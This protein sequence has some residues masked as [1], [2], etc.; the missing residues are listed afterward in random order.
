MAGLDDEAIKQIRRLQEEGLQGKSKTYLPVLTESQL[1]VALDALNYMG[2]RDADLKRRGR[3]Q[4]TA[5]ILSDLW[6]RGLN[7]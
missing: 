3:A 4:E 7:V 5:A 1:L 6:V 2:Q